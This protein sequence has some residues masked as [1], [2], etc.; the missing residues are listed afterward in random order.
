ML[1][2][3]W[4]IALLAVQPGKPPAAAPAAHPAIIAKPMNAPN[5]TPY[6]TP[7]PISFAATNPDSPT[8]AGSATTTVSWE[9]TTTANDNWTLQV[10]AN[11]ASFSNCPT[12]IPVSAVAITCTNGYN[13]G[14]FSCGAP[15]T[16]STSKVQ[17]ASGTVG[18]GYTYFWVTLNYTLT[19]NWKYIAQTSSSCTLDIS[20]LATVN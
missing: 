8:V 20:Y 13:G 6:A 11:S 5:F 16:L 7:S 15:A 2:S 18:A 1:E 10:Y 12:A 9:V 17:V 4:L 19:D 14:A 3:L